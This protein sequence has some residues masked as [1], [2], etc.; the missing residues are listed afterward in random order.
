[1][2]AGIRALEHLLHGTHEFDVA[3]HL[4]HGWPAGC[5]GHDPRRDEVEVARGSQKH[6]FPRSLASVLKFVG[7]LKLSLMRVRI[8]TLSGRLLQ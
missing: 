2:P 3:L 8:T 7:A 4:Q 6:G 5:A 1:M